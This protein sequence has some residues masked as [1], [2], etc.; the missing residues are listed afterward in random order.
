ME[1]FYLL[2]VLAGMSIGFVSGDVMAF[3]IVNRLPNNSYKP[4]LV[5]PITCLSIMAFTTMGWT[6]GQLN[7]EVLVKIIT[8][9]S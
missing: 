1:S 9:Y 7:G 8:L 6:I 5:L 3:N 4:I 2:N